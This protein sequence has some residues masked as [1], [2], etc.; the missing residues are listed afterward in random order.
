MALCDARSREARLERSFGPPS[1]Q[2]DLLPSAI[3]ELLK[4]AGFPLEKLSGV[5]VG[6]GP[7][8]FTG[9]RIGLATAK[10]LAYA[11]EIPLV[12][13]SSLEAAALDGPES[14][15]L[16]SCAVARKGELYVGGY[17]RL[18]Q[19]VERALPIEAFSTQQMVELLNA[20]PEA[21]AI[22]PAMAEVR[23][24]LQASGAR[25][26]QLHSG[27]AFPRAAALALLAPPLGEFDVQKLFSLEPEYV[28]PSEAERNPKF[29]PLPG[30]A[31]RPKLLEDT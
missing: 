6:L 20:H 3:E 30:A 9:L 17:R 7:G 13:A 8:S 27:P 16:L 4:E 18:G 12:G 24:A 28:R 1:R 5:V 29:P 10:A 19:G 25:G 26:E 23:D 22:G 31:P 11:F 2:S 15:L 14:V 21:L